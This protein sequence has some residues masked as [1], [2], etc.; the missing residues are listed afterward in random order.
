[1]QPVTQSKDSFGEV[2]SRVRFRMPKTCGDSRMVSCLDF[3]SWNLKITELSET[4]HT[5][6]I[7]TSFLNFKVLECMNQILILFCVLCTVL[8]SPRLAG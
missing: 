3:S 7:T 8:E 1:M 2:W 5:A 4:A 6:S